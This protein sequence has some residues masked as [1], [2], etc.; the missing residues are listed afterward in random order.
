[1]A[2]KNGS[3]E[4]TKEEYGFA[5]SLI[6]YH[7]TLLWQEFGVFFLAES[8]LIGF[9]A[10]VVAQ[11]SDG[12][13]GS[14]PIFAGSILGLLLCLPWWSTFWHNY[15]YYQLRIEQA[16]RVEK[17]LGLSLMSEGQSLSEGNVVSIGKRKI[18][19]PFLAQ[20]VPPRRGIPSLIILFASAFAAL[21]G[22]SWPF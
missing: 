14:V 17:K 12:I 21:I 8:V 18:R 1:M 20:L 15:R 6:Q 10:T 22:F 13:R 4:L 5:I 16:L 7:V 11:A 19:L 9:L 3:P 2:K